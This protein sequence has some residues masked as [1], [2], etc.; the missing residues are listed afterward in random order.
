MI[1][2][3]VSCAA[4]YAEPARKEFKLLFSTA[5]DITNTWGKL[6]FGATPMQKIRACKDPGFVL[7]CCLPQADGTWEVYG[8]SYKPDEAGKEYEKKNTWKIVHATTRDGE[9]F[10]NVET[11][12]EGEPGAVANAVAVTRRGPE[13]AVVTSVEEFRGEEPEGL[14]GFEVRW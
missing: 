14:A 13:R 6:H 8:Q 1:L 7:A 12:F 9:H 2:G 5:Q 11:V 10:E 3:V 4:S